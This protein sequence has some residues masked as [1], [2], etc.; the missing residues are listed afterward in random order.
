EL[1]ELAAADTEGKYMQVLEFM[2]QELTGFNQAYEKRRTDALIEGDLDA[3]KEIKQRRI[4][5][6]FTEEDLKFGNTEYTLHSYWGG[7]IDQKGGTRTASFTIGAM[8]H[9]RKA[10]GKVIDFVGYYDVDYI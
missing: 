8:H 1:L 5:F 4:S 3:L 7:L 9:E 10:W 2:I 6:W